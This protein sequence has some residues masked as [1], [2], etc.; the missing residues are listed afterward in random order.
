VLF[1]KAFALSLIG[2][3]DVVDPR[4]CVAAAATYAAVA[5]AA[6]SWSTLGVAAAAALVLLAWKRPFQA[7]RPMRW[8]LVLP[9]LGMIWLF[10]PWT[11]TRPEGRSSPGLAISEEGVQ[12]AAV[13]SV[14]FTLIFVV[15]SRLL[16]SL[17]PAQLAYGMRALGVPERFRRLLATTVRYTPLLAGEYRRLRTSM[18]GRGFAFRATPSGY[19][20]MAASMGMLLVRSIDRSERVGRAIAARSYGAQPVATV[21]RLSGSDRVAAVAAASV[22]LAMIAVEAAARMR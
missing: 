18:A 2:R 4:I 3:A 15:V 14:R 12:L 19:R 7:A 8:T 16:G 22:L 1:E 9:V 10:V 6:Q 20:T 21:Q 11:W 17:S 5:A 13:V